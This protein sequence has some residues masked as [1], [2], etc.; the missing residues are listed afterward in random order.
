MLVV[1]ICIIAYYCFQTFVLRVNIHCD[2]C[3]HKVKKLLKRTEGTTTVLF[4]CTSNVTQTHSYIILDVLYKVK[5][6]DY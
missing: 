6:N 1:F 5:E 4:S 2:G 3:K